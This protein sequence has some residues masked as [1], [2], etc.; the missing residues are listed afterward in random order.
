M[1]RQ[2]V[3]YYAI[4]RNAAGE[5]RVRFGISRRREAQIETSFEIWER[6][7][8]LAGADGFR[9]VEIN[10]AANPAA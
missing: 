2:K 3:C 8:E 6:V 5:T 7:S 9:L 10:G 1:R 4:R